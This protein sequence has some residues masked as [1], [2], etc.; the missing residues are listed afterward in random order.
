MSLP[1]SPVTVQQLD[2]LVERLRKTREDRDAKEAILTEANKAVMELEGK[3]VAY[4]KE[5]GRKSYDSPIGKITIVQKV[6]V[7][8]PKTDPDKQALFAWLR[9]KGIADQYLTVNYN[10]INSLYTN[11]ERE[12]IERG[13]LNFSIPGVGA[14]KVTELF[15]LTKR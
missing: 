5:L 14:P 8:L 2:E 6:T 7:T 11:M 1:S 13:E 15:R 9:E 4:L 12:A 10:S 3:C